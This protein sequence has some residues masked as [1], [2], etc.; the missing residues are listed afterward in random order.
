[1]KKNLINFLYS[2]LLIL[3]ISSCSIK[4]TI[5][6]QE[7]TETFLTTQND[8]AP[9]VDGI[10]SM[11]YEWYGYRTNGDYFFSSWGPEIYSAAGGPRLAANTKSYDA[12]NVYIVYSPWYINFKIIRT[13]NSLMA[14]IEPIEMDAAYKSRIIG[15]MHYLRAFAYFNL[16]RLYG[17][18]PVFTE[19]VTAEIELRRP[20][21][22]VDDVYKLIFSDLKEASSRCAPVDK[23]PA[24]ETGHATKGA[25]QGLLSLAYLTYANNLDLNSKQGEAKSSYQLAVNYA[26]SV[27]L[28][29]KY[30]LT[31]KFNDLFDVAKENT[32]YNTGGEVLFGIRFSYI[33][34]VQ[35]GSWYARMF[36]P[37]TYYG[38][39]GWQPYGQGEG[40][41][42]IQAWFYD[43]YTTGEYAKD[44]RGEFS[45]LSKWPQNGST[46]ITRITYPNIPTSTNEVVE[47]GL[48]Y[49][50][51]YRDGSSKDGI[52]MGNDLYYLRLAEIYLIKAEAENELNGPT[53][54][55]LD[56]FNKLR[57]RARTANG[58]SRLEPANVTTADVP[59]KEDFRMKIYDERAIELLGEAHAF[60]DNVRMRCKDNKRTMMEYINNDYAKTLASGLPNYNSSNKIWEGGRAY[61]ATYN[62]NA[63]LLL[64]PVPVSE[65]DANPALKG[66]QNPGW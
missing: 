54:S 65:M 47:N 17:K 6:D 32:A 55:A 24:A 51:K 38:V 8:V 36:M 57:E 42:R 44:Y 28:S 61:A 66:D 15:E 56:A 10:Y 14:R 33:D 48:P 50:S 5:Y 26:D 64:L 30:A 18:L 58:T 9:L 19:D 3:I 59:T 20:R 22:S 13:A 11:F 23:L 12:T 35:L 1:M 39:T 49:M 40:A 31:P 45:L 52:N 46:T 53:A 34:G 63:R 4:E 43:K 41:L 21:S 16:V 29:G 7:D 25:A 27:L 62:W 2:S 37:T 60:F